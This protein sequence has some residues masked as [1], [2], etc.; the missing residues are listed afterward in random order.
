MTKD[1]HQAQMR[2][3]LFRDLAMARLTRCI[4]GFRIYARDDYPCPMAQRFVGVYLPEEM[5]DLYP[6]DCP[7][8][9]ACGCVLRETI[10]DCDETEAASELLARKANAPRS[11]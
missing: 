4:V 5:P 8:E 9:D 7:H 2:G 6:D 1:E 10:L 11:P 3:F